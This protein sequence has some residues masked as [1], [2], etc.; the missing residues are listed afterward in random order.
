MTLPSVTVSSRADATSSTP[1]VDTGTAFF[2]GITE[3]GS[4]T[5]AST[6]YRNFD[7]WTDEFGGRVTQSQIAYD[8]VEAYFAEGGSRLYFSR[9]YGSGGTEGDDNY[10]T[11][12]DADKVAAINRFPKDLGPGQVAYPGA[13]STTAHSGILTHASVNNRVA[14]LDYPDSGTVSS[15][16]TPAGT[17]RGLT[18]A[19]YGVGFAPWAKIPEY[20]VGGG[21]RTVPYSAIEAGIIARNDGTGNNPNIAAAGVNGVSRY[22]TSLSQTYTTAEKGTLYDAG[23]NPAIVKDGAVRTYGFNTLV[24][25]S[26]APDWVQANW[27]RVAMAIAAEAD[28]IGED[29]LFSQ[30]DGQNVT[31][32]SFGGELAGML[33]SHY[34]QGSLYGATAQDA[35]SVDIGE[36]V[37]TPETIADGE[38]RAVLN[39]R[40]SPHASQVTIEVVKTPTEET[41]A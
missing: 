35:F 15:L 20:T 11:I 21:E 33:L 10:E 32:A 28:A 6:L 38:L 26:T 3:T 12:V 36:Q 17:D 14:L 27:A 8:S 5:D 1:P 24:N 13:T 41:I 19:R 29:Y 16:T 9:A 7:Q 4:I 37:N 23:V 30:L 40:L 39:V 31:I 34:Q 18:T 25:P 2:A 22:A